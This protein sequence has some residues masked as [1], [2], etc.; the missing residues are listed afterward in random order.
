VSGE[1]GLDFNVK[2]LGSTE[3]PCFPHVKH[4]ISIEATTA[5]SSL[6][7]ESMS[8]ISQWCECF[9]APIENSHT[10]SRSFSASLVEPTSVIGQRMPC[11]ILVAFAAPHCGTFHALLNINFSDKARPNNQEFTITRELRGHAIFPISGSPANDGDSPDTL[12]VTTEAEDAGI[13]VSPDPTLEF[14]PPSHEPFT[15]QTKEFVITRSSNTLVFF[16]EA[17][18]YSPDA[19][20]ME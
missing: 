14:S 11:T 4:T 16:I 15:T 10:S 5:V 8:L 18:I 6:S 19:S 17:S 13:I 9:G 3:C 12:E 2:G 7:V 1:D 20:M